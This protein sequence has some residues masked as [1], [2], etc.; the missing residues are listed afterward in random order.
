MS[1]TCTRR[2]SGPSERGECGCAAVE[3]TVRP[4]VRLEEERNQ[5]DVRTEL[6]SEAGRPA[7]VVR[8]GLGR[9]RIG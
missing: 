1:L 2:M 8:R 5:D 9:V 6:D 7:H 3:I 4:D